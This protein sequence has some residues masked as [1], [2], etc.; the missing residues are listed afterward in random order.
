MGPSS[1]LKGAQQ[2]P[3]FS[4]MSI[5]A[6]NGWMPLDME[7]GLGPGDV[8]LD[9]DPASPPPRKR[10]VQPPVFGPC[11]LSPNGRPSQLLLSTCSNRVVN[12]WN[13]LAHRV[14]SANTVLTS[15]K[16]DYKN[17]GTIRAHRHTDTI[18]DNHSFR[19][20]MHADQ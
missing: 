5:M 12:T 19:L 9:G 11:L 3:H 14:V 7:V 1:P 15:L 4:T 6:T 17:S 8:V 16:Q 20:R 10:W 18:C 13:S 2:P